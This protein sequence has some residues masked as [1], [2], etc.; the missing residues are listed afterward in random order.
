MSHGTLNVNVWMIINVTVSFKLW[1]IF[2]LCFWKSGKVKKI[3]AN[4]LK[5]RRM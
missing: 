5:S 1:V 2:F 4:A 3:K